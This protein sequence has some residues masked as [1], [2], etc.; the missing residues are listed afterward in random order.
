MKLK[1]GKLNAAKECLCMMRKSDLPCKDKQKRRTYLFSMTTTFNN[2]RPVMVKS[3]RNN[4]RIKKMM[5][6]RTEQTKFFILK[7]QMQRAA[8]QVGTQTFKWVM[9]CLLR[10]ISRLSRLPDQ[11]V[12]QNLKRKEMIALTKKKKKVMITMANRATY[13]KC[14]PPFQTLKCKSRKLIIGERPFLQ[15]ITIRKLKNSQIKVV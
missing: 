8:P 6:S 11:R 10:K 1:K 5:I 3:T 9:I 7:D 13:H 4:F 12:N 15:V 14:K 2:H